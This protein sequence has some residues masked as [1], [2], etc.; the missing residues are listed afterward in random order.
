MKILNLGCGS[1]T[2]PH[3]AVTNIDWSILLRIKLNP[4]LRFFAPYILNDYRVDRFNALSNNIIAHDLS[5]GIP[6]PDASV[7]VVYHSH[8]LE[9]LDREVAELFLR[10]IFRVLTPGGILRVVVPD[11]ELVCRE[12]IASIDACARGEN[13]SI[14]RHDATVEPVLLAS[15]RRESHGTSQ[16]KPFRRFIE[17]RLLGDARRR[18]DTHQWM[19]DRFNLTSLVHRCGYR[20]VVVQSFDTSL[21]PQWAEIGLDKNGTGGEYKPG[22]VYIEAIKT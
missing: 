17:N 8:M 16:Q 6:F 22:S 12:Y 4:V 21:I 14:D 1:K 3:P 10:E 11:F 18:G 9:H 2:S 5:K 13:G 19:Y 20:K 15:V 7:D